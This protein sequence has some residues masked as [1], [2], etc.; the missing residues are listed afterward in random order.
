MLIS[1]YYIYI[2]LGILE[3]LTEFLPVSSTGHLI[4]AVDM[5]GLNMPP[6]KVFEISI[7]LGAI[8]AICWLYRRALL[9]VLI[10]LTGARAADFSQAIKLDSAYE[11]ESC[12]GDK[13]SLTLGKQ[14]GQGVRVT[15]LLALRFSL[16]LIIAFFP[17]AVLGLLFHHAIKAHLFNATSVSVMLVLGGVAILIIERM[18]PKPR[19]F[20][21]DHIGLKT[22]LK[23]GLFQALALVPGVSRSGATIMGSLLMGLDRKAAAEFSFFLAIPTMFAATLFDLLDSLH[24][25]TPDNLLMIAVGFVSAFI[26]ALVVVRAAIAFISKYGFGVFA[27]YRIILGLGMLG[28]L[29][30]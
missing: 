22:A 28:Y 5:F 26:T 1:D 8:L 18:K 24:E 29:Y 14:D 25:L 9:G 4:L 2:F 12:S 23:I 6:G 15:P 27:Y 17:A 20:D 16:N 19:I 3:G 13:A 30:L 11:K 21:V 10:A 7:Q